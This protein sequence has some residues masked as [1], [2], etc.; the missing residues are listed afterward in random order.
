MERRA[1]CGLA[2]CRFPSGRGQ[3]A[4]G[5][6][7]AAPLGELRNFVPPAPCNA[8]RIPMANHARIHVAEIAGHR[9]RSP[10]CVDKRLVRIHRRPTNGTLCAIR[11]GGLFGPPSK[12]AGMI[13]LGMPRLSRS[14][15]MLQVVG[16][17]LAETRRALQLS[18]EQAA[19]VAGV[20]RS[21]W[22]NWENGLRFPDSPA[23]IRF[24]NEFSVTM[25]W[26]YRGN[27]TGLPNSLIAKLIGRVSAA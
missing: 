11:Q 4:I 16:R 6:F 21:A 20:T 22:K 10:K 15:A 3:E 12:A 7:D 14:D 17:R 1:D 27:M 5:E 24:C 9:D 2:S 26:I 8:A 19:K 13:I 25:D 18:Q 23:M